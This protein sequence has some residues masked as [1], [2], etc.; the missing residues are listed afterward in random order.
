M[1]K[2]KGN[3]LQ[4]KKLIQTSDL[5]TRNL[6]YKM[7]KKIACTPAQYFKLKVGYLN[8]NGNGIILGTSIINIV[9]FLGHPSIF[10]ISFS[11]FDVYLLPLLL[12]LLPL[13]VHWLWMLNGTCTCIRLC[14]GMY[15]HCFKST[16]WE[17]IIWK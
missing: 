16:S 2:N 1:T 7:F 17:W 6:F 12:L 4:I 5:R 11:S 10:S 8:V 9:V 15:Q 13:S 14:N 3:L